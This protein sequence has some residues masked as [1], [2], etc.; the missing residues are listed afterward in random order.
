MLKNLSIID[1]GNGLGLKELF[2]NTDWK[3]EPGGLFRGLDKRQHN[4]WRYIIG[5]K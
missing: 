2:D 3:K 5:S 4:G 1:V